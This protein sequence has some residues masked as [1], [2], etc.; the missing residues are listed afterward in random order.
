MRMFSQLWSRYVTV[1]GFRSKA[2][3]I[4]YINKPSPALILQ[5]CSSSTGLASAEGV[6]SR[7]SQ[8]RPELVFNEAPTSL[9]E[10][11]QAPP[12]GLLKWHR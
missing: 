9:W 2:D 1:S 4:F 10:E 6:Q 11:D 7:A 3:S 8:L 12:P 5:L